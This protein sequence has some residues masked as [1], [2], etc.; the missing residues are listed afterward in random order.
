MK[1]VNFASNC[2]V[3]YSPEHSK[4][5]LLQVQE[6]NLIHDTRIIKQ[7]LQAFETKIVSSFLIVLSFGLIV[8]S[9]SVRFQKMFNHDF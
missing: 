5:V 6:P 4:F 8:L 7:S 2:P 3:T 9:I 1:F